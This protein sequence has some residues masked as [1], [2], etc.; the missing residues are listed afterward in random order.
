MAAVAELIRWPEPEP[1]IGGR[2]I[3]SSASLGRVWKS[4]QL[5]APTDA[6][7]MIQGE[8][9]TGKELVARAIH[10]ESLRRGRA[11]CN[12]QL[13]RDSWRADGKRT[14]RPRARCLHRRIIAEH[15]TLSSGP[16][17]NPVP[18]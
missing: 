6:A 2:L 4:I 3:G 15:W 5:V 11:V 10:D 17:R 16:R 12:G 1:M 7:V 9:G 8:T 13:R 14:V 18:G